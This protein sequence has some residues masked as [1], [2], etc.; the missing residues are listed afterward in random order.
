MS[1]LYVSVTIDP[2]IDPYLTFRKGAY[3]KI[4]KVLGG[5]ETST[6]DGISAS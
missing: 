3:Y 1:L 6:G 5:V 2:M 4:R